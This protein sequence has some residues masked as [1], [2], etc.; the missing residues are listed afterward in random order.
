MRC[1]GVGLA[2]TA[3]SAIAAMTAVPA[4]AASFDCTRA[5]TAVE[6]MICGNPEISDLDSA[7]AKAY[8]SFHDGL[9]DIV[10]DQFAD[11][12]R[13]S[14]RDWLHQR[15]ECQTDACLIT[16]YQDRLAALQGRVPA[17]S[18]AG[19]SVNALVGDYADDDITI[20]VRQI[21]AD[22]SV[23]LVSGGGPNWI[24]GYGG[25]ANALDANRLSVGTEGLVIQFAGGTATITDTPAN[26][27]VSQSY[28]GI[29][30]SMIGS[31]QR[32]DQDQD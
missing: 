30:G 19:A 16:A 23:A 6:H 3:M 12:V 2:L 15:D 31:Y 20:Q 7:M 27:S 26:R 25:V 32:Q 11:L 8:T 22:T 24:C 29:A 5:A 28:C 18:G 13:Q 17:S 1:L 10:D 4:Q 21:E 14:Q 9:S